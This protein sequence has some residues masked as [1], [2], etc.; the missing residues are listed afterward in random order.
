MADTLVVAGLW[1]RPLAES[2]AQAGWR[3][4][5]LDL[6][7]DA[8]TRRASARWLRIG[9]PAAFALDPRLLREA[10]QQAAREPGVIGWVAGSGF[11]AMPQLLACG[12]PQLPLLG[13]DVESV[14]RVRD[15]ASFF[16]TL[17]R[18]DLPH[19]EVRLQPPRSLDGWLAKDARGCGGWQVQAAEHP[20]AQAGTAR[21]WQRWQAGEPMSALF[22][23]DGARAC[24]VA[25]NRLVIRALGGLRFIFHG[26]IGPI[27]DPELLQQ[28]EHALALLVPAFGLRGLAS[29]DFLAHE[30]RAWLLE[31]NARPS[32]TMVLYGDA[33]P[34]GLIHAHVRAVQ[35]TLPDTRPT[36]PPGLRGDRV[37]Y[38][39]QACRLE[40]SLAAELAAA[41]DCHDVPAAGTAF[42]PHEPVCSIAAT[43][44]DAQQLLAQL[45]RRAQ[46]IQGRLAPMAKA[47]A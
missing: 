23:A 36:H 35:G 12:P 4:I 33:W 8:D 43:G 1:A 26:A 45:D 41:P 3:V 37:V 47:A 21:Y 13:M 34:G 19:P 31:I 9:D 18:L 28:M 29:L 2:A 42:G 20:P 22:L 40:S 10:L 25:L 24:V 46:D 38:A 30:G 17:D 27:H 14:R 32:A 7:G 16:G 5:A 15:P 39:D 11:E 6:Y 44:S